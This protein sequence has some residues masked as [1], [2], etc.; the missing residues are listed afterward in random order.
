MIT[1]VDSKNNGMYQTRFEQATMLLRENHT[2]ENTD[3]ITTLEEYFLYLRDLA[4]LDPYYT[5]LPI[6]EETLDID[7]DTR[8]IAIPADFAKNGVGVQGD[9][10]AEVLYFTIDRFFDATD[11]SDPSMQIAI[12]WETADKVAGVS[13]EFV[14]DV[15][16]HPGKLIFGWPLA[17]E[18]TKKPG[19]VKFSVRFYKIG[20]RKVIADNGAEVTQQ[21]LTYNFNTIPAELTINASLDY[22]LYG[23]EKVDS[24]DRENLIVNRIVNSILTDPAIPD[25]DTP[26]WRIN[27]ADIATIEGIY[28]AVNEM[29]E[30][31]QEQRDAKDAARAAADVRANAYLIKDL[32]NIGRTLAD[33]TVV[34]RIG[35]PLEVYATGNGAVS[36]NWLT[37]GLD[38]VGNVATEE[39]A[40]ADINNSY[41]APAASGPMD[42]TKSYY[43]AVGNY[44]TVHHDAVGE[45]GDEDYVPAYDALEV[46]GISGYK[47]QPWF[48][49]VLDENGKANINGT[50]MQLYERHS[51]AIAEAAGVY[52]VVAV[53][54]RLGKSQQ[55]DSYKVIFPM[56]RIPVIATE[57]TE[58]TVEA[59]GETFNLVQDDGEVI[60]VILDGE[61]HAALHTTAVSPEI[62]TAEE[63]EWPAPVVALSYEWYTSPGA[64]ANAIY[65]NDGIDEM[66]K[67]NNAA[68]ATYDVTVTSAAVN[69]YDEYFYGKVINTRNLATAFKYTLPYRVTPAPKKPII[70]SP[71]A[72]ASNI[73]NYTIGA[74]VTIA[75]GDLQSDGYT[76][77]WKRFN[78]E[79]NVDPDSADASIIV[80]YG[81]DDYVIEGATEAAYKPTAPGYYYCEI[82]NHLNGSA[83]M[84][85]TPFYN[86]QRN[87]G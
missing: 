86:F 17:S 19:K 72:G 8:K 31:T 4:L 49:V 58:D 54:R 74:T 85:R 64:A 35:Y 46:T 1:F 11:L 2:I 60:H 15:T 78:P 75:L 24:I 80:D 21:Y 68:A 87:E 42:K 51:R 14:R 6:D 5:M 67:I 70:T 12:Q 84:S 43:I 26:V 27:L 16:S 22:S 57:P 30:T 38:V 10:I 71:L 52:H 36:Y 61:N 48:D 81:P 83:N 13:K 66:Y 28:A 32:Y 79:G 47:P 50:V 45:E 39:G 29:P 7:A 37:A 23:E 77:Q 76:Y 34:E 82:T 59:E 53:N 69:G 55:I 41:Y 40:V 18:I 56:P 65:V 44:E 33:G 63:N 9:E 25:A 20:D 73:R 62:A 3:S